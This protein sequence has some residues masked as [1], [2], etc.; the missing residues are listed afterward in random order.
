MAIDTTGKWWKGQNSDDLTK[1]I[2]LLT[3]ES[4]VATRFV[5]A[6]C[7][8]GNKHFQLFGD[9]DEGCAKR[10][11]VSCGAESLI[12]DSEEVWA[13]SKPKK[14]KCRCKNDVY[15][16]AVGFS[17]R[18]DGEIKWVTVGERCIACGML[19]SYVDWSIKYAPTAHLFTKV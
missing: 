11:C 1:Y 19:G 2:R 18:E 17:L 6:K 14:L 10:L 16:I 15:E 4:H 9:Q 5:V 12:C 13:E 8:C 7:S 3:A